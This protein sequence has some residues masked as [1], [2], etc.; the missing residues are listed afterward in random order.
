MAA[1]VSRT[2]QLRQRVSS[3]KAARAERRQE[4]AEL[5]AEAKQVKV[6]AVASA[7]PKPRGLAG[8]AREVL[9]AASSTNLVRSASLLVS[10]MQGSGATPTAVLLREAAGVVGGLH[11]EDRAVRLFDDADRLLNRCDRT[12]A[13]LTVCGGVGMALL[14]AT[15]AVT[16]ALPPPQLAGVALVAMAALFAFASSQHRGF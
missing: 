2:A 10:G 8:S 11:A 6:D 9:S 16:G 12:I 4:K 1:A 15:L 3:G 13:A 5:K 14:G 7:Q